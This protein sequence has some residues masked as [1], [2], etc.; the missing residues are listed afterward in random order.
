V[1]RYT[2]SADHHS[3]SPTPAGAVA[4]QEPDI[5]AITDPYLEGGS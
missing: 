1:I 5:N 4:E 2:G 3:P